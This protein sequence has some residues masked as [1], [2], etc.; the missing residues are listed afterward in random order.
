MVTNH[1]VLRT[2]YHPTKNVILIQ[3]DVSIRISMEKKGFRA[4]LLQVLFF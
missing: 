3:H 1:T 2:S 4:L